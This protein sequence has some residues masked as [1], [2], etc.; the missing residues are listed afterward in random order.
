MGTARFL[1]VFDYDHTIVN[2]NTDIVARDLIPSDSIPDDVK[3]LYRSS[4]WINYMQ[5]IFDLLHKHG[6][7]KNQIQEAIKNIPECPG[8]TQCIKKLKENAFDVIVISDSNSVF[9]DTWNK[10]RISDNIDAIFTNPAR[11]DTS[12]R[13]ELSS[14]FFI[15]SPKLIQI[16]LDSV[17]SRTTTK[18]I[19]HSVRRIFVRVK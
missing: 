5:A 3:I 6:K 4:G 13:W 2:D 1:A 7:T 15:I 14:T 11:F 18:N 17:S 8:M 16:F 19:A 10:G 9:I 12:E